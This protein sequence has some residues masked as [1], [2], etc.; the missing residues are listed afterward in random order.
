MN[1]TVS[2]KRSR[3]LKTNH[4]PPDRTI[5]Y[6]KDTEK[7][8]GAEDNSSPWFSAGPCHPCNIFFRHHDKKESAAIVKEMRVR[9][10]A[11]SW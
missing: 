10:A 3:K 4:Q 9:T 1:Q 11:S 7:R 2:G 6:T 5:A 8:K